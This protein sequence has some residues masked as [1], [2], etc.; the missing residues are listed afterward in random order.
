MIPDEL[1]AII[2]GGLRKNLEYAIQL[3]AEIGSYSLRS[4]PPIIPDD[5]PDIDDYIRSHGLPLM[6]MSFSSLFKRLMNLNIAKARKEFT[7]W[8]SDDDTIFCRLRIWASGEPNLISGEDF[9]LIIIGLSDDAFWDDSHQRDLLLV[10]SKRWKELHLNSKKEIENRLLNGPVNVNHEKEWIAFESLNRITWLA[11]NHCYFTFDLDSETQRLLAISPNWKPENAI[12][13]AD[14][15]ESRGG[16]IK[17]NRE[18]SSLLNEPRS[19][20]LSKVLE[21]SSRKEDFLI[22]VDP[23]AGLSDER[24]ARAFSALTHAAKQNEY[25]EWAWKKFLCSEARKKDKP[26]FSYLIAERLSSYPDEAF[27]NFVSTVSYWILNTEKNLSYTFPESFEKVILKLINILRINSSSGDTT[28]GTTDRGTDWIMAALNSPVGRIA[29]SIFNDKRINDLQEGK[30]FNIEWLTHVEKLLSLNDDLKRQ[31]IVIFTEKLNWFYFTN[32]NWSEIHLLSILRG[33]NEKDKD[34]FLSGFL[35]GAEMPC[36]ELYEK[37]KDDLMTIPKVNKSAKYGVCEALPGIIFAGWKSV[38]EETQKRFISNE[39]MYDVLLHSSEHFK[40]QLLWQLEIWF[41]GSEEKE[42]YTK[43]LHVF[44][45]DVWPRQIS[46]KTSYLSSRLLDMAFLSP[47]G[48]P[49][50]VKAILPL[51]TTINYSYTNI[52]FPDWTKSYPQQTLDLLDIVLS[53]EIRSWPYNVEEIFQRISDADES[54]HSDERLLELKRKWNA[55]QIS[56]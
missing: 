36:A 28:T 37:I 22:E 19:S 31:A 34:A 53:D 27:P 20:I 35:W 26:K 55:R 39:E 52:D 48:F 18:Y 14:S 25:P 54:L 12:R 44:F 4:I 46:A 5:R 43:L 42:K 1:L 6:V 40:I 3:E 13:T 41:N 45:S 56:F 21:L 49:E 9:G 47:A 2:M 11:N 30:G 38:R 32:S 33:G 50:L 8:P 16:T 7:V 15:R 24:P 51:L 10:L 23:F 29:R 17:I